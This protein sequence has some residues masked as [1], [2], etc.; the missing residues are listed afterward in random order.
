[1][2][3]YAITNGKNEYYN[4]SK[5]LCSP[6]ILLFSDDLKKA[7]VWRDL[8]CAANVLKRSKE[9]EGC[10]IVPLDSKEHPWLAD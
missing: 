2:T 9:S 8:R 3:Y 5:K 10:S 7:K 4:G 1:M 6:P